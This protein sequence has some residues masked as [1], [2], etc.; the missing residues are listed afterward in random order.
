MNTQLSPFHLAIPVHNLE[1][2]RRFYTD[3]LEL[4]EGRSSEHWVDFDFYGHQLV[5]HEQEKSE[6]STVHHAA[7][8][9]KQVPIPHFGLVL[10]WNYWADFVAMLTSKN[11]SFEIAP[12]IRFK[13]KPGEQ[14]TLFFYD[15]SGNALEF[16]SFKNPGSLFD[17]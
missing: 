15:P 13:G 14:A 9:Q 10:P 11:V 16:K 2:A 3:I 1:I 5:I 12:Y 6:S 4:K 7:V 8:D 17:K